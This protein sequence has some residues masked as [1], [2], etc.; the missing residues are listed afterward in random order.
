[1]LPICNITGTIVDLMGAPVAN[2]TISV[3]VSGYIVSGTA[4][5]TSSVIISDTLISGYEM[6]FS[7]TPS[8]T[9]VLSLPQNL[10]VDINIP[11]AMYSNRVVI[12][13]TSS[14]GIGEL[15]VIDTLG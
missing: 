8:G 4:V 5:I 3:T 2:A 15:Q 14:V 1:M 10:L 13:P 12:P 11:Q 7:T 6:Q 9:F